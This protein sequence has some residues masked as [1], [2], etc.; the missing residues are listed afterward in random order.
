MSEKKQRGSG[1]RFDAPAHDA[2]LTLAGLDH[3]DHFAAQ[4]HSV[5]SNPTQYDLRRRMS[6]APY[7]VVPTVGCV[8]MFAPKTWRINIWIGSLVFYG[9]VS[10]AMYNSDTSADD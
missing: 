9:M 5:L 6:W 10:V 3:R 8:S 2:K 7:V 4:G 1:A